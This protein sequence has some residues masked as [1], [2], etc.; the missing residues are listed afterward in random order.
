MRRVG[1]KDTQDLVRRTLGLM[2]SNPLAAKYSWLGRRQKVAFKEFALA[3]LII[4]VALNVKSPKEGGGS[5][6]FQLAKTG[7]GQDEKA[8]IVSLLFIT[9]LL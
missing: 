4:E 2:I 1:G 7:Q 5:G 8:R 9:N 3:K 6:H